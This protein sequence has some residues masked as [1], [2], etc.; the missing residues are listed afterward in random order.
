MPRP[1]G[2]ARLS[3]LYAVVFTEIGIAMPFMPL[4]LD[5]LG[6]DARVIGL[7]LALPIATRI[8]ATA[9][10][11]SLLDRGLGPRR[12][13]LLGSLALSLTYALMPAAA[14]I[15]WPW[16]AALIVLNAVA[17]APLV[18]CIDYLTLAAV[19]GDSRLAYSRIRMAGS[20]AFLLANLAGGVLLTALGGRLAVPLLL[21]GLALGAA[22]VAWR[23]RAVAALPPSAAGTGRPRL[24]LKLWLCIGAA[25]AIQASHGAIYGF[26]SIYWTSQGIPAAWVGSLWATGV[27]AEIALFAALPALPAAWRSPVRLL[28]AGA[29]AA[30][31]RA[32]GM[33][34]L[35]DHLA[36]LVPLQCLH[37]LT[38]GATQLGAMAAVSAYA[39][40][41]ARGR[42]QG[43]LSAVNAG[44]SVVATLGSGVAYRAGGP[45]AFLLMAPLAAAGLGLALAS[46]RASGVRLETDRQP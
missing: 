21:T 35:G 8:A 3:L 31:L 2:P 41:G 29:V 18:P 39:P 46:R 45:L 33:F 6:L 42:A 4:W 32:V 20:V 44:I 13:I 43:T 28:G 1:S 14:G 40:D 23:S 37:G 38:F 10:L 25:A 17:G 12:L 19:R 11:M 7:L 24:P 34:L 15:A 27:L 30:I 36:A 9:P 5:A 22:L 26:G 16:L